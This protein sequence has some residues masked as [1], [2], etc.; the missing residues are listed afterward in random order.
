MK[1]THCSKWILVPWAKAGARR[2]PRT[3]S[4]PAAAPAPPAVLRNV[5]RCIGM[6]PR[7]R[8]GAGIGPSSRAGKRRTVANRYVVTRPSS[9]GVLGYTG[10]QSTEMR[11]APRAEDHMISSLRRGSRSRLLL[12]LVLAALLVP[13]AA[14]AQRP[15]SALPA[16]P[17]DSVGMSAA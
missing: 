7:A 5:R 16:A 11:G 15:A 8:S 13:S 17:A 9:R 4:R 2:A 14:H 3:P 1:S 6:D 10:G 12:A